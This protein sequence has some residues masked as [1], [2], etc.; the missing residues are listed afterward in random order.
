[1]IAEKTPTNLIF[2]W[3]KSEKNELFFKIHLCQRRASQLKNTEQCQ[4]GAHSTR[5]QWQLITS[6]SLALPSGL[7]YYYEGIVDLLC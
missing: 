2:V 1:M 4:D 6:V 7:F 5:R 3:D